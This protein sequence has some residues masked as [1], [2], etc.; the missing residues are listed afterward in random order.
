MLRSDFWVWLVQLG[1]TNW[2]QGF[3][4]QKLIIKEKF[5][6]VS[7]RFLSYVR[8]QSTHFQIVCRGKRIILQISDFFCNQ[9]FSMFGD[10]SCN[11]L[12]RSLKKCLFIFWFSLFS[13]R[14]TQFKMKFLIF[15]SLLNTL[16]WFD[17]HAHDIYWTDRETRFSTY[18]NNIRKLVPD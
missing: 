16:K 17:R 2:R 6:R 4:T 13:C 7:S 14:F 3:Q 11:S 8:K 10:C 12:I 5:Q 9:I 15:M 18:Q 1:I